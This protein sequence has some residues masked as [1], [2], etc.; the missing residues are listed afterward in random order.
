MLARHVNIVNNDNMT[1]EQTITKKVTTVLNG[2]FAAEAEELV[3]TTGFGLADILRQ[4]L[5]RVLLEVRE[6]GSF[7]TKRLPPRVATATAA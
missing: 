5:I 7:E 3:Q 2:D 1:D 6:R 4:G